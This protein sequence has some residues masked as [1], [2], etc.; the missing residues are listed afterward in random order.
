MSHKLGSQGGHNP[1][2]PLQLHVGNAQQRQQ[3]NMLKGEML[4]FA[5]NA[6]KVEKMQHEQLMGEVSEEKVSKTT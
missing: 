3:Y 6:F 2:T 1:N 5:Q 4:E